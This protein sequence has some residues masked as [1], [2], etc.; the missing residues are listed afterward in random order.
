MT[1]KRHVRRRQCEGKARHPDSVTAIRE[2]TRLRKR[3]ADGWYLNVYKCQFCAGYHV[4][5]AKHRALR[6]TGR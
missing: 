5:H 2:A 6:H 1:S 3:N 4:G